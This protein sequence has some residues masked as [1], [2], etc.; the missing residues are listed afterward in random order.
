MD[1]FWSI[2]VNTTAPVLI[3]PREGFFLCVTLA[4]LTGYG[5]VNVRQV[6]KVKT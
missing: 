1:G 5:F 2:E 4:A 6:L 3:S